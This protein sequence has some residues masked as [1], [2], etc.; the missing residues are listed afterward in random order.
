MLVPLAALV[1]FGMSRVVAP[2][3][4]IGLVFDEPWEF[5]LT[6]IVLM[7]I[8]L[9]LMAIPAVDAR[10]GRTLAGAREP[11]APERERL[12][13]LLAVAAAPAR[14]NPARLRLFVQDE[15]GINAA[16][17]GGRLVFVTTGALRLP[18]AAL[19]ALLAH[20]LG[21]HRDLFPVITAL[22]WWVR[23]PA[24]P[25]RWV[26]RGLRRAIGRFAARLPRPLALLG[27]LGQLLVA[28][29]EL[30][31]LWLVYLGE[32]IAAWLSRRSEFQA[33]GH[34]AAWGFAEPLGEALAITYRVQPPRPRLVR[35]FDE[36]P[37]TPERVQR[38]QVATS[39]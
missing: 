1:A 8:S 21:H 22:I 30:N 9:A 17:G 32:L 38:L 28:F 39:H 35:L 16:A 5:G 19:T 37:P 34:A 7:V 20:E 15:D 12:D 27:V 29:I 6:A 31:L 24:L 23:L 36:H 18:D 4:L 10:V 33:D 13:A 26:A 3:G 11:T 14:M 25:I 2:V